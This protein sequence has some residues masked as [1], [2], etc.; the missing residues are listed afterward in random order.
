MTG[1]PVQSGPSLSILEF[2]ASVP[3]GS[4]VAQL[5]DGSLAVC[6]DVE[7]ADRQILASR[8]SVADNAGRC[9]E[10]EVDVTL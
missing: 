3:E 9:L 8:K 6:R 7:E 2:L 10:T 5:E 4:I 1:V